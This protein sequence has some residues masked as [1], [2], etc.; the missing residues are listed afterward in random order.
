MG[1]FLLPGVSP[2]EGGGPTQLTFGREERRVILRV[3]RDSM[4]F[5]SLNPEAYPSTLHFG[6][7]KFAFPKNTPHPPFSA[8][9]MW[10]ASGGLLPG[11]KVS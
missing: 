11:R 3:Y 4:D 8:F 6:Y 1:P 9:P 2:M 5:F 7:P 10:P